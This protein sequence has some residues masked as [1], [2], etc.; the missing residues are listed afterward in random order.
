M[1]SAFGS[2]TD[3]IRSLLSATGLNGGGAGA[4]LHAADTTVHAATKPN[5]VRMSTC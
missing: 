1:K 2:I 5:T 4:L 3:C